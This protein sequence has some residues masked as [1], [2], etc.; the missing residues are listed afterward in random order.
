VVK[1]RFTEPV[2]APDRTGTPY[3][4]AATRK[5]IIEKLGG[6]FFGILQSKGSKQSGFRK[7]TVQKWIH[8]A[9]NLK[10]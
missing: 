2:L 4:C 3:F 7:R 6:Y 8:G 1:N 5:E 10:N 9:L